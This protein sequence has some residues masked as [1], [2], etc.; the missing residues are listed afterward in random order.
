MCAPRQSREWRASSGSPSK[1]KGYFSLTLGGEAVNP[2]EMARAYASLA[3]SGQRIDGSLMGNQ[4]RAVLSIG[5]KANAPVEKRALGDN[6]AAI[7]TRLLQGVVESGTGRRAQLSDGRPVAG[8]TGTTENYGDAWFVGY[9]PQLA[10]AV[11]VGYPNNL[12]PMLTDYH[13][14]PVA[15][16]T[17]PALIFKAFMEKALPQMGAQPESFTPPS[18]PYASPRRIVFRDGRWRLDNGYCKSTR[19]ILYFSGEGPDTTANCKPNEVEVPDVIG[20]TYDEAKARL[21]LQPLDAAPIYKPARPGQR[22]GLVVGELPGIRARLSSYDTVRLVVTKATHGVVPNVVG[23]PVARA[24]DRLVKRGLEPVVRE[25]AAKGKPGRVLVQQPVAGVAAERRM[26]V[27]LV[28]SKAKP[29][30]KP[31]LGAKAKAPGG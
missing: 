1:L 30:A 2:L 19:V 8:K 22:V 24:R 11:W 25:R 29:H 16:G 5:K 18:Y 4:P 21:A 10:V 17:F 20:M 6:E 3:N 27:R 31:V 26:R 23:K 12:R 9:T 13:G 14:D 28:V 7:E 15:G